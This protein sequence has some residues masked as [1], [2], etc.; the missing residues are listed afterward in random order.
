MTIIYI[1]DM[2]EGFVLY[3]AIPVTDLCNIVTDYLWG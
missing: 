3:D 1:F 2:C